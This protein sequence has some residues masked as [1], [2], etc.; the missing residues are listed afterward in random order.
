M[1]FSICGMASYAYDFEE[2]GIYYEIIPF[3]KENVVVK[4][5]GTNNSY[6]GIV[7]IPSEVTHNGVTYSV[8]GISSGA[9]KGCSNLTSVTLP[10]SVSG[11]GEFTFSGC[12]NLTSV[13]IPN[14]VTSIA[15]NAFEYCYRITFVAVSCIDE[16]DFAKYLSRRDIYSVFHTANLK[17]K[18]HK[19]LV[20]GVEQKDVLIPNSVSRIG[21]SAFKDCS[22]L[23]SITIPNFVKE[24]GASAFSGCIGL[25]SITIP[26]SVTSIGIDAFDG[27]NNVKELIYAEGCT[28]ALRTYLTSITSIIIPNSVT[29]IGSKAFQNSSNLTTVTIPNSVTTIGDYAFSS[30]SKLASVTIP[31]SVTSI[32]NYAF[33][34]V[35]KIIWLTNTPPSGYKYAVGKIN[36]VANDQFTEIS[37]DKKKI[38]P[39]LSS[40]FENDG[41]KYVPVSPSERTCDAIDCVYDEHS[42]NILIEEN[43]SYKGIAMK[44]ENINPYTCYGNEHIE[45]VEISHKGGIGSQAFSN[46]IGL[47]TATISNQW[48]IGA[49]AFAGCTGLRTATIRNQGNIG[50]QAFSGCTSLQTATISNQGHIGESAFE[51]C[52]KSDGNGTVTID[53]PDEICT[54][55]FYNCIGINKL[56]ILAKGSIGSSAF[57]GC[58]NLANL[59]ITI[60]GN[61]GESAFEKSFQK[62]Y[63][64]VTIESSKN[65]EKQ[66]FYKC[67]GIKTLSIMTSG[68]IGESAFYRCENIES[69]S[70]AEGATNLNSMAFW[71]CTSLKEIE[72][73]NSVKAIG[74]H[75]FYGCESLENVVIGSGV[76]NIDWYAFS[77]CRS[78]PYIE[79]PQNVRSIGNYA[80]EGC[81][82]LANV[83]IA[84]R[85]SSLSLGSNSS[86]VFNESSPLFSDCPLETIYIGGPI[87]YSKSSSDGYS[88]F[89]R[90]TSLKSVTITDKEIE[91]YDNE[92]YGCTALKDVKIGDGVT[93]I[94]NWAFS[95]C[96][97]LESFSFGSKTKNIG[98]EAFSDCTALTQIST[99]AIT[100]P[101][102]G[103]QALDDINKWSCTL[104]VPGQSVSLYQAADQWKEFFFIEANPNS[105]RRVTVE[106]NDIKLGSV[107]GSGTYFEGENVTVTATPAKGCR[108]V[109]WSN[110]VTENPYSFVISKDTTLTATFELCKYTITFDTDGGSAIDPIT[111]D[112]GSVITAPANPTKTGY[113]FV[114]WDKDIPSTM[115][116]EDIVIKAIWKINQYKVT[117]IADVDGE[118]IY[119]ELKDYDSVVEKPKDPVKEG[120]TFN[121]WNVKF[122]IKVPAYDMTIIGSFSINNYT[123]TYIFNADVVGKV[124]LQYGSPIPPFEYTPTDSRYTITR[125]IS[126][127]EYDTMPAKDI[128][129]YAEYT[130][131]IPSINND[132]LVDV[133]TVN[134]V[135]IR[136]NVSKSEIASELPAGMYIINGKKVIVK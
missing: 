12:S 42:K 4:D 75:A 11:I 77:A 98:K 97:S 89:Y 87:S 124:E 78:L 79:I 102:C 122:P 32:G 113:T 28:V 61:I 16:S 15:N 106:S 41:I 31:N 133:Y 39:Y 132:N 7:V 20:N 33:D 104:T 58:S 52:F 66:A 82:K 125:W 69:A 49:Q 91:V 6:S 110:G 111:A 116:D 74:S 64:V 18:E 86:S 103:D 127:A 44:V 94:G 25:T 55:A 29:S 48:D 10:N 67:S 14:S 47:Q 108:F 50:S 65:I 57:Y 34:T 126:D 85:T 83:T 53:I 30:C 95:G 27:C 45:S 129:F 70:I 134:G 92:F 73:P 56:A 5:N 136:R 117:F 51:N 84:D 26:N 2:G 59:S 118:I 135:K 38:Y 46:C 107:S 24:I 21:G 13:T 121:G 80:F 71:G 72:I 81:S 19:L 90:N 115:P 54:K 93:K 22:C 96:T 63:G 35:K 36:Y 40:M 123:A 119:E 1:L 120:H 3:M 114:G 76:T 99:R 8:S 101:V 131:G 128:T 23:T 109:Q 9:F 112:Y 130:D 88:P 100:P 17:G 68:Y 105:S 62:Y 60:E 37:S 43:V